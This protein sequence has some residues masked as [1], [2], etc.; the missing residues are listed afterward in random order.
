MKPDFDVEFIERLRAVLQPLPAPVAGLSITLDPPAHRT[1]IQSLI[2]KFLTCDL[3]VTAARTT[4]A[5]L[6]LMCIS[7]LVG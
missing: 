3:C 1:V 6:I 5:F 2:N 7:Y 4:A